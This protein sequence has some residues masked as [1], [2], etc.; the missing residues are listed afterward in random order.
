MGLRPKI[1][2]LIDKYSQKRGEGNFI[3]S[4]I[5]LTILFSRFGLDERDV[6]QSKDNF[7]SNDGREPGKAYR[8]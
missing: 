3:L 4:W 8:R 1:V 6:R 7:R 2:K 5:H